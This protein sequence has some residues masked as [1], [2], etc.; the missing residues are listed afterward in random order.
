M[1]LLC[2][3]LLA[4]PLLKRRSV[5]DSV[6]KSEK[7]SRETLGLV[8]AQA[9]KKRGKQRTEGVEILRYSAQVTFQLTPLVNK[10]APLLSQQYPLVFAV[11]ISGQDLPAN[12]DH[13]RVSYH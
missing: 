8:H 2:A 6:T 11:H 1:K 7:V 12:S 5:H 3:H 9:S 4:L 10:R 13:V